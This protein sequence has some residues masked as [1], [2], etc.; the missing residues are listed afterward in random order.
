MQKK[1]VSE[2]N[3]KKIIYMD[4]AAT[5]KM[6]KKAYEAMLPYFINLYGNPSS[7]YDISK[8]ARQ[9]L[10]DA[11]HI[12]AK[13]I[14]C[15][16]DEIY[17]TS[18]GSES[19]NWALNYNF[20][21]I[22]NSK[23]RGHI[24]TTA[25]EHH[26]ILNTCRHLERCG[27]DV[28]YI[29]PDENGYINPAK[30]KKAIRSN[31]FLISV[32]TANNEIGTI[33]DVKE[34]GRIAKKYK[35]VFHSDA[36]Q[37]FGHIPIDVK[38]CGI[39][40]LS[41]SGHK[42]GGPKGSGVLYI[43]ENIVVNP[44]IY[45]G[46]QE[47]GKRGGTENIPAIKAM[48]VAA[49]DAVNNMRENGIKM[50]QIRDYII[51]ELIHKIPFIRINGSRTKRLPNNIN[52]S[53][54]YVDGKSLLIMLDSMGICASTGSA[55]SSKDSKPSHVLIAIGL[56]QELAYDSIRLTLSKDITMEEADYV[57]RAICAAVK[58]L[59]KVSPEYNK[60]MQVK[61]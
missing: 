21:N 1:D 29:S 22:V 47:M 48:S 38:E 46:S 13:A 56:T 5:T 55:C 32:M 9:V 7:I 28:T 15:K 44:Y 4:N 51:D 33:Q 12:F 6:N 54:Q 23:K 61:K 57:V 36:V 43:S 26:A 49:D 53:I 52:L 14:N 40:L 3:T 60:I 10:V 18:G 16:P 45:G 42:F 37:A 31:T 8:D 25:I 19:D 39:D 59:R 27:I 17:F 35:I 34:I 50:T 11:R 58:K 2:N 20:E 24:I 41:I 30:I